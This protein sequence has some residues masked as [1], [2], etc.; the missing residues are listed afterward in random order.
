M[1]LVLGD[2]TIQRLFTLEK[3]EYLLHLT[4][5][6]DIFISSGPFFNNSNS[7]NEMTRFKFN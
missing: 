7:F 2:N 5:V 4:R 1:T 3:L 6:N